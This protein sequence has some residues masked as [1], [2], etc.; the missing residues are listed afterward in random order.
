MTEDVAPTKRKPLTK[1]Q[2]LAMFERHKGVCVL[3]TRKITDTKWIDEHLRPLAQGGSNDISNR[4]PAHITC[5]AAKTN[6][7]AGDNANS[8]RAKRKK[9]AAV[10][11]KTR[12]SP[13]IQSAPFA[14]APKQAKASKPLEKKAAAEKPIEKFAGLARRPMFV[15][16]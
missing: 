14:P 7:P 13:P 16:K 4:G 9:E 8:A 1:K 6:G 11:G 10:I 5:A 3:C 2:R 15:N 12:K